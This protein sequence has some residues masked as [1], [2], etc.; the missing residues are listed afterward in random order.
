MESFQIQK[1]LDPNTPKYCQDRY[2]HDCVIFTEKYWVELEIRA[3]KDC[4]QCDLAK[5][6][7]DRPMNR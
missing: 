1:F 5:V 7:R 2:G 6:P 4:L 3:F